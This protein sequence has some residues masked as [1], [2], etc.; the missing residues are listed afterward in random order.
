MLFVSGRFLTSHV[1]KQVH[2]FFW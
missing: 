2:H 1:T